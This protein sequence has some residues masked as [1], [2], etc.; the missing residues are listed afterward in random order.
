MADYPYVYGS[1]GP[2]PVEQGGTRV[3]VFR[4]RRGES[5][6]EKASEEGGREAGGEEAW[7]SLL[8]EAVEE[9]NRSFEQAGVP[10]TCLLDED[11]E[12]LFLHVRRE[13]EDGSEQDVEEELLDP[14]DLPQ[15]LGRLRTR[16]GIL[17]DEKA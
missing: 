11:E 17:L 5:S 7:R 13:G 4:R 2:R 16:L 12:G 14:A 15:W 10:F 3:R 1:V 9:L 8:E 6:E